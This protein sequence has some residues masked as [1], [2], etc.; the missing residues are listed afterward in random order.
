MLWVTFDQA[1]PESALASVTKVAGASLGGL[2]LC[3]DGDLVSL[4]KDDGFVSD[5]LPPEGSVRLPYFCR[6]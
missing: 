5:E 2:M 4:T 3:A 1:L 6:A